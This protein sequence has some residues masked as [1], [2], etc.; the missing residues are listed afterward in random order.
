M[1]SQKRTEG[2][3]NKIEVVDD[4]KFNEGLEFLLKKHDS[5]WKELART[6]VVKDAKEP[7]KSNKNYGGQ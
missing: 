4:E 3:S 2:R 7:E 6:F 5:A 1:I